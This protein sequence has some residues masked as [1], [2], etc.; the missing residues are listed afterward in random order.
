MQHK[1][2]DE[3]EK[4]TPTHKAK[5]NPDIGDKSGQAFGH[6][7][8]TTTIIYEDDAGCNPMTANFDLPPTMIPQHSHIPISGPLPELVLVE[9]PIVCKFESFFT[10]IFI[11]F[12]IIH[13]P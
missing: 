13:I 4:A 7:A 8:Q 11:S 12:F 5:N 1:K 6:A 2:R 9:V 3:E 10:C